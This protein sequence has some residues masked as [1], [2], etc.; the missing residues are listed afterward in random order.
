MTAATTFVPT[1][2]GVCRN[3]QRRADLAVLTR[4]GWSCRPAPVRY[5]TPAAR[6]IGHLPVDSPSTTGAPMV[7]WSHAPRQSFAGYSMTGV[8]IFLAQ[9]R[10]S[11]L[12]HAAPWGANG[13]E[14][15]TL[16]RNSRWWCAL[17]GPVALLGGCSLLDPSPTVTAVVTV[18]ASSSSSSTAPTTTLPSTTPTHLGWSDL[19]KQVKGA[20]VRLDVTGCS[21]RWMGTGFL[22]END[23]VLTAGH[24]V[25]GAVTVTVQDQD[26]V[27]KGRVVDH[28]M[29]IDSGLVR[30]DQPL[31]AAPL[32][33]STSEPDLGETLAI[34]GYPLSSFDLRI[35]EGVLSGLHKQVDYGTFSVADTYI[36][37]AAINGGNSGGPVFN[38]MA[39]VVGLVT[40]KQQ[41]VSGP[42]GVDPADGQGFVVPA[43]SFRSP[44]ATWR[45]EPNS[46]VV[47]CD[48][49]GTAPSQPDHTIQVIVDDRQPV[50]SDIARSL[51]V[52]GQAINQGSY[53]SAWEVFTPRMQLLMGGL[54]QWKAGLKTSFWTRLEVANVSGSASSSLAHVLLQTH[55]DAQ[56]GHD[57]QSCSDWVFDYSLVNSSGGWLIDKAKNTVGSPTAC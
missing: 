19:V 36:T 37:D 24:V 18:T 55:Q 25:D 49:D 45:Q 44:L 29:S 54:D 51:S 7:G 20:V 30:L 31:R 5:P 17:V 39:Q 14:V 22:V 32:I 33:L 57:G 23:L 11:L 26:G 8:R 2:W 38:D 35:T 53:S 40:G 47:T 3:G 27:T 28:D 13:L 21:S 6:R 9:R 43:S 34:L 46:P 15:G 12:A 10:C 1:T 16:M 48:S 50:A 56:F 4:A 52:H 42:N 41:Y